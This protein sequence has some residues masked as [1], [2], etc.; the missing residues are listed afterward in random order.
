M[1][2][3]QYHINVVKRP[4]VEEFLARMG[5]IYEII[6]YTASLHE[7]DNHYSL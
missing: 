6:I 2:G 4:G 3:I 7:V 5:E 1:G